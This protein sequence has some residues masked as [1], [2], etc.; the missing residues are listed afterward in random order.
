MSKKY[1]RV[2][3][4]RPHLA[5]QAFA[6]A[7]EQAVKEGYTISGD[8]THHARELNSG[9]YDITVVRPG[10]SRLSHGFPIEHL[11]LEKEDFDRIY[12]P[13][14]TSE[15]VRKELIAAHNG[16]AERV[17]HLMTD[18]EKE[19]AKFNQAEII[20]TFPERE[21]YNENPLLGSGN[22]LLSHLESCKTKQDLFDFA[23]RYGIVVPEDKQVFTAIKKYIK[24]QIVKK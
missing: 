4:P 20:T 2:D 19:A 8:P 21:G 3:N 5:L 1:I 15:G 16:D 18:E 9:C 6:I 22:P 10:V 17:G 13:G 7:I 12:A 23:S 11:G 24:E 14:Q